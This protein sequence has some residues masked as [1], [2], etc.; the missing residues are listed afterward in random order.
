MATVYWIKGR[1][2]NVRRNL[3]SK[4]DVLMQLKE[5]S[6]LMVPETSLAI[7]FN[8]PE[9]GYG[10][11]LPPL[12]ITSIFEKARAQGVRRMAAVPSKDRA[13]TAIAGPRAL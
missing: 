5:V 1:S 2:Q 7:K 6:R 13:T 10:H 4:L 11:Y 3:V 9:I 8:L 12:I